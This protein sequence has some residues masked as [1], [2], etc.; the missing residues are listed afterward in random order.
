MEYLIGGQ[1]ISLLKKPGLDLVFTTMHST[2]TTILGSVKYLTAY[3]QPYIKD[4]TNHIDAMDLEATIKYINSLNS[5]LQGM[6][7][8]LLN[9]V[10]V[11][12]THVLDITEQINNEIDEFKVKVEY[13]NS[14]HLSYW[15]AF[16][17]GD[18]VKKL[19]IHNT[20]LNKRLNLL[21]SALKSTKN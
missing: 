16:D 9:N 13:H 14:K 18:I 6:Q 19:D 8:K 17:S 2:T 4:V 10:K 1:V 20:K 15:R 11:A 5:D 21:L 3:D 7:H 12:L